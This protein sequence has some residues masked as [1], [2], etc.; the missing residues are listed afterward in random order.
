MGIGNFPGAIVIVGFPLKVT[1]PL[2]YIFNWENLDFS[3]IQRSNR[4][5]HVQPRCEVRQLKNFP[6]RYKQSVG[7]IS[8]RVQMGFRQSQ[9]RLI[10]HSMLKLYQS[11]EKISWMINVFLSEFMLT[12]LDDW[13]QSIG[14]I[15]LADEVICALGFSLNFDFWICTH[16]YNSQ[17]GIFFMDNIDQKRMLNSRQWPVE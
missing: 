13:Y 5:N 15:C 17:G 12:S 3:V 16:H 11:S 6:W 14:W 7:N 1:A 2:I 9:S 4:R 8:W 10:L